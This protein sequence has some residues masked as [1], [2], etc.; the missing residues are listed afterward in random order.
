MFRLIDPFRL[1]YYQIET[2]NDIFASLRSVDFY[3][4]EFFYFY[5]GI[6]RYAT[7]T[8]LNNMIA[9]V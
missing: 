9:T 4:D 5:E 7:Q 2:I 1:D 3:D 8:Q 6:S